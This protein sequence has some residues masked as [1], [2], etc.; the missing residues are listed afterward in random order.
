[1]ENE[2][3]VITKLPSEDHRQLEIKK[4]Q[5]AIDGIKTTIPKIIRDMVHKCLA[6]KVQIVSKEE[7]E[8]KREDF[9]EGMK[10]ANISILQTETNDDIDDQQEFDHKK[11]GLMTRIE[12]VKHFGCNEQD[13]CAAHK[14]KE[15]VVITRMRRH[16]YKKADLEEWYPKFIDKKFN[17]LKEKSA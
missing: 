13:I 10:K 8:A 4:H 7:T 15:L 6:D 5:M 16:Y 17:Q 1:M 2:K 11:F 9:F 3:T 14:N 12:A